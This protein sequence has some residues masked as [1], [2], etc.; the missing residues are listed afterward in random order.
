MSNEKPTKPHPDFPLFAYNNGQWCKK[1][2]GK[3][4]YFG[5]WVDPDAAVQCT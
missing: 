4:R 1:I 3:Q 5:A 2:R